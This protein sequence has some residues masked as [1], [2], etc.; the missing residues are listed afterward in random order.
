MRRPPSPLGTARIAPGTAR[1]IAPAD[2][3]VK[4]AHA[5]TAGGTALLRRRVARARSPGR[6]GVSGRH[7]RRHPRMAA[8]RFR[9]LRD[10]GV[11]QIRHRIRRVR[12]R[13][14]SWRSRMLPHERA[15]PCHRKAKRKRAASCTI[16]DG[17]LGQSSTLRPLL[18][19][20]WRE[21][22]HDLSRSYSH[23]CCRAR[24]RHVAGP[25][26]R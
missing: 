25:C 11:I 13:L 5:V 9:D 26:A 16:S 17:K 7:A 22:V 2:V 1:M 20:S 19:V 3:A 4:R 14:P 15:T 21:V 6:G 23:G 8:S 24:C 18:E 12:P 10:F